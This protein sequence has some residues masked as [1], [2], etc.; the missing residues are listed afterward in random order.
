MYREVLG[1]RQVITAQQTSSSGKVVEP[2]LGKYPKNVS[3]SNLNFIILFN[4][5]NR[6]L[7]LWLYFF[8]HFSYI[9]V[10]IIQID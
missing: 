6:T 5:N 1:F 7:I 8:W 4:R 2:G 3:D 10:V 9:Y